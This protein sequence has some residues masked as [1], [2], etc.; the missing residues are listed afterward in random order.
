MSSHL[1]ITPG[2]LDKGCHH[3]A[4]RISRLS[5]CNELIIAWF[6]LARCQTLTLDLA[7]KMKNVL[8]KK[9]KGKLSIQL[10]HTLM[11][12]THHSCIPT[13]FPV[14]AG[15]AN[16]LLVPPLYLSV[17]DPG[18]TCLQDKPPTTQQGPAPRQAS[19]N[20]QRNASLASRTKRKVS[21]VRTPRSSSLGKQEELGS[22]TQLLHIKVQGLPQVSNR[23]EQVKFSEL[24]STMRPKP[25]Q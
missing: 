22:H 20:S 25:L 11:E 17:K 1:V 3:A 16:T 18:A 24:C 7:F 12:Q 6:A 13:D 15:K 19:P 5:F 14:T 21:H 23:A 8:G 4:G 2:A 10:K 9:I